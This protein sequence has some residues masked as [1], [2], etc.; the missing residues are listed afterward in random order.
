MIGIDLG[1]HALKIIDADASRGRVNIRGAVRILL[2]MP[3]QDQAARKAAA[4][5]EL[6]TILQRMNLHP[7]GVALGITGRDVNMRLSF[8]P[9][10]RGAKG[11]SLIKY[12]LMQVAG[13]SEGS[14]YV[15]HI[16]PKAVC[17]PQEIGLLVGLAKNSYIDETLAA[18][19]KAGARVGHAVPHS[20]ALFNGFARCGK[21]NPGETV[22]LMD[23]GHEN[24][25]TA[26]VRDGALLF[27]RNVASG[28]KLFDASIAGFCKVSPAEAERLKREEGSLTPG[29]KLAP[30]TEAIKPALLNALA[31]LQAV[32]QSSTSFARLQLKNPSMQID[33][34]VLSGGGSRLRGLPEALS[35]GIGKPVELF[36]P[37]ANT[38]TSA[39]SSA[40]AEALRVA[41]ADMA[42]ALGLALS[43]E[44]APAH[45]SLMPDARRR[46]Q[47]FWRHSVLGYAGAFLV[48]CA[49]A[50]LF[51]LATARVAN[52]VD[53]EKEV[54]AIR[55]AIDEATNLFSEKQAERDEIAARV[56]EL[57][58][59]TEPGMFFL[60]VL[61]VVSE[62]RPERL[63]ISKITLEHYAPD[64]TE[65]AKSKDQQYGI[66]VAGYLEES[67][68]TAH[69]VLE[70]FVKG[71]DE[72]GK[73]RARFRKPISK[74][75]GRFG[76]EITVTPP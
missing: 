36:D 27:A 38:N 18:V 14:V 16:I 59:T 46:S 11:R 56:N 25:E 4:V 49:V 39:L 71:L 65:G 10:L 44:G 48:C 66:V 64:T 67:D 63:W 54:M 37:I 74:E 42:V 72:S 13:R 40:A 32:V 20:L 60:T 34:V 9:A 75:T 19:E 53:S 29:D 23:I 62:T 57:S 61:G 31:Q 30:K 70:S 33:R 47:R 43:G 22:L 1:T 55:Q 68:A 35:S 21:S 15:D 6:G 8:I 69:A 3:D 26:F 28:A 17:T 5:K 58:K 12:E 50:L 52:A 51:R 7:R 2:N 76:F 73:M 45:I 24:V 41:S